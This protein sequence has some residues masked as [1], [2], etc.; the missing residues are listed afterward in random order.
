MIAEEISLIGKELG[1]S[2]KLKFYDDSMSW[3]VVFFFFFFEETSRGNWRGLKWR[4]GGP[5][6]K[7]GGINTVEKSFDAINP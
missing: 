2:P 3:L 5:R 7:K 4:Q 1:E 6:E